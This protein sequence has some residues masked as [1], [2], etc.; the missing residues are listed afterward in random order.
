MKV[1]ISLPDPVFHAAEQ[2][3]ASLHKPRSQLYAEALA[4]YIGAHGAR[5]ITARLDRVYAAQAS[6]LDP[7]LA[8]AQVAAL[9]DETW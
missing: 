9:G 6:E 1:A 4:E 7:A 5:D 8:A 3:A 2:L